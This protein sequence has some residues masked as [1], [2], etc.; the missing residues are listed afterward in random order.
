MPWTFEH[1][2]SYG[3]RCFAYKIKKLDYP[4]KASVIIRI[5]TRKE[6]GGVISGATPQAEVAVIWSYAKEWQQLWKLEKARKLF[7]EAFRSNCIA[8]TIMLAYIRLISDFRPPKW[9]QNE[10]CCFNPLHFWCFV[11]EATENYYTHIILTET[12]VGHVAVSRKLLCLCWLPEKA[13]LLWYKC[14]VYK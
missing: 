9:W 5:L 14:Q 11:T 2:N 12:R 7:L 6:P 13:S 8:D 4:G 10:F 1:V 3:Q